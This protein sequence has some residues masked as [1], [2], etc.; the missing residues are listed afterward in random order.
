[1]LIFNQTRPVVDHIINV[2]VIEDN[3]EELQ[4]PK[5]RSLQDILTAPGMNMFM[6]SSHLEALK[7]LNNKRF[8][9]IFY[10]LD[11]PTFNPPE[12]LQLLASGDRTKNVMTVL[13]SSEKAK[14]YQYLESTA[15]LS[16]DYLIKPYIP[17]LVKTKFGVYKKLHNRHQRVMQLL[18]NILPAQ[19]L[20]EFGA[21]GKSSPKRKNNCSV[22]FT[23]FVNFTQKTKSS[24][25][26]RL[27]KELDFYFSAF[28]EIILK[29]R[30][31]KIKTI[32][33]A[34]MAAA[35]VTEKDAFPA[36]RTALAAFEIQQF[37]ENDQQKRRAKG[38]DFWTIRIGIHCGDLVAGVVGKQKFSFD[39]WGDTVNIA[40]RCEQNSIPGKVNVSEAFYRFVSAYFECTERGAIEVKNGGKMNMYFLDQLKTHFSL[41]GNGK[42]PNAKL[43]EALELPRADFKGIRAFVLN[44]LQEEL[45]PRLTYHSVDHTLAVEKAVVKYAKLEQLSAHDSF[46]LQTAAIFHDTGFL[47]QYEDNEQFAVDFLKEIAP[48][49]GY[50][51]PD[52]KKISEIIMATVQNRQPKNLLE[53]I[54]RDADLDYL[55]RP[56]YHVTAHLLFEEMENFATP[57]ELEKQLTIQL[58]Y[59]KNQ[60]EYHTVSA[61]N[62]RSAGKR[63]RI[64]EL[65]LALTQAQKK[66]SER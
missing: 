31:E 34:Y 39:V 25:P 56:D 33:D 1:M 15:H 64:E 53:E 63:K 21:Y 18:E 57:V 43:R 62:L 58:D 38:N 3:K 19:T 44:K 23:D 13:S 5:G 48:K 65:K 50:E 7:L 47:V 10:D 49:F 41:Y 20:E 12:F 11:L 27:V 28:D 45:D 2:L 30:L 37:M 55:G 35:G 42:V 29:Y 36:M 24:S 14:V 26:E 52:I 6:A 46:L 17:A 32:G 60:H 51:K 8:A 66:S 40:A 22:L 16:L 54:M 9:L 4:I 59:L 61:K